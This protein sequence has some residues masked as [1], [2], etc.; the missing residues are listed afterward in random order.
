M[1]VKVLALGSAF[2]GDDAAGLEA[3]RVLNAEGAQVEALGRPGP[4]LID[5]FEVGHSVVIL[6]AVRGLEPGSIVEIPLESLSQS[7]VARAAN[8]THGMGVAEAFELATAL[9]YELPKGV[10]VGI[11]G[12]RFTQGAPMSERTSAAMPAFVERA[13]AAIKRL[14]EERCT[15][16]SSSRG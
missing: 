8:S 3:A 13:R 4:S 14:E 12:E 7:A 15:N 11:G 10:F 6:D 5:W 2:N 16:T 1:K 9:G